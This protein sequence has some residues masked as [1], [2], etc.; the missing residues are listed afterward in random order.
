VV[1]QG[2]SWLTVSGSE[3][4]TPG[5]CQ[6]TQPSTVQE[7][8]LSPSDSRAGLCV[9]GAV[10]PPPDLPC[11]LPSLLPQTCTAEGC[12]HLRALGQGPLSPLDLLDW[13][14]SPE[15]QGRAEPL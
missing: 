12:A 14:L 1:L 4:A 10:P 7:K 9:G 15:P 11:H 3:E 8:G 5:R 6:N 13:F 2:V